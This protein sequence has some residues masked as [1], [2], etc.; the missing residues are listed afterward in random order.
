MVKK[1]ETQH[2]NLRLQMQMRKRDGSLPQSKQNS[3]EAQMFVRMAGQKGIGR[4]VSPV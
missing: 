1:K 3:K 2:A 4:H